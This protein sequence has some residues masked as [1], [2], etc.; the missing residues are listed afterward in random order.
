MK[1]MLLSI[2]KDHSRASTIALNFLFNKETVIA[3]V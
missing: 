1:N 2:T 3:S